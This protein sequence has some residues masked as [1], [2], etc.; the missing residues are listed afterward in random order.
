VSAFGP[1]IDS[2]A[3]GTPHVVRHTVS[4]ASGP[5]AASADLYEL[6]RA[7]DRLNIR[8]INFKSACRP[9]YLYQ[10]VVIIIGSIRI[11]GCSCR[12]ADP[13]TSR[14]GA[15]LK[16]AASLTGYQRLLKWAEEALGGREA[17][18][19]VRL[20]A[21]WL[22]PRGEVVEDLAS[23]ATARVGKLSGTAQK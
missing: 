8:L 1:A 12:F 15:A 17:R 2:W 6:G 7:V 18:G 4:A 5:M 21:Q 22:L 11:S 20:L 9:L 10:R 3:A 23:T 16:S 13:A 19:L 14:Q